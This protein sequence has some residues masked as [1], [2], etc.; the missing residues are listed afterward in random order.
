MAAFCI[1]TLLQPSLKSI[2]EPVHFAQIQI[3]PSS[4]NFALQVLQILL[5]LTVHLLIQH[6]PYTV[7]K[8]IEIR[9]V[10]RPIFFRPKIDIFRSQNFCDSGGSVARGGVQKALVCASRCA[11]IGEEFWILS[12]FLPFGD[13]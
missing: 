9:G 3:L 1:F 13:L 11:T 4:S 8:E 6:T 7:V 2:N 5:W 12:L 10:W